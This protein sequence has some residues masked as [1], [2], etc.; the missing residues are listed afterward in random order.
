GK[1]VRRFLDTQDAASSGNLF[2]HARQCWGGKAISQAKELGDATRVHAT[3]V[4]NILKTGAI[5]EYFAPAKKGAVVYSNRPYTKLEIR[6]RPFA[7][8][9]DPVLLRLMKSGRPL[10]FVPSPRMISRDV[11]IVFAG[12]R[13]RMS[14]MLLAYPGPLHFGTDAWMSPNHRAFIAFTV[15]LEVKGTAFSVLLD[16]VELAK[17]HSGA[18]MAAAFGEMLY[19]LG[20]EEK[21]SYC[22][23]LLAA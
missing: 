6:Y 18:N 12:R 10:F 16:L 2:K 21:V 4:T 22:S 5:T 13:H 19:D 11:K 3:L 9:T 1:P 20:L 14:A 15:H 23:R 17:S 7:V 8:A